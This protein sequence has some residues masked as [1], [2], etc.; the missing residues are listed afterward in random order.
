[1]SNL[2][3]AS[4]TH[5]RVHSHGSLLRSTA[6]V[7]DL[8]QRAAA[9]G[10]K[11]LALTDSQSLYSAVQFEQV[12]RTAGLQSIVGM[13]VRLAVDGNGRSP[14]QLILLATGPAGYQSLCRL[15]A[16]LQAH[17]DRE[18]RLQTGLSWDD[19]RANHDGLICIEAGLS[20]WLAHYWQTGQRQEATHFAGR[21]AAIFTDRCYLGLELHHREDKALARDLIQLGGRFG[22]QP[23]VAQPITHLE[24]EDADLLPLLAAIERNG[25]IEDIQDEIPPGHWLS[26]AEIEERFADFPE[27]IANV[28]TIIKQCQPALPN[29]RTIWPALDLPAGQTVEETLA[30]QTRTALAKRKPYSVSDNGLQ[31]TDYESRL[32]KELAAITSQSFA[33]LFL[34]VADI[35]RFA[36]QEDVPVST[37]G[38][39]ANSLVAYLLGITTVDPVEQGLLF[40]RFLNPARANLPDIDL[41]FCSRRRDEV[42]AYVRRRYGEDRVAMVGTMNTLQPKSAIRETAKAY[43]LPEKR[44]KQ[45][46]ALAPR[47]WH[48]DPRR[49]ELADAE[50]IIAGLEDETDQTIMRQAFR[51]VGQPDH[52]SLHPGGIIITPGPLTNFVPVQWA[53]KGFLTTQYD[54]RDVE[55]IGLPKIDLLGIRALTVLADTAVAIRTHHNPNFRLADIPLDDPD[56]GDLLARGETIGVFQCESSGA[57]RTLRQLRARTVRDLAVAN[58]FFKPGP[59]TGG[60]A[61]SFVRRYRGEEKV[62]YLHPSLEPI[63]APTQGVLLFQEQVLRIA[64]EIAGLSWAQAD[65]LRRGMSKFRAKEMAAMRLA[66]VM[67]CQASTGSAT[68]TPP[69]EPVE[70]APFTPQQA[71]TLWEQVLA[72]AGY[73]FNQGHATAYA[74]V[75]YRSAYLKTHYPAEFLRARLMDHGGFHHPAVYIAEARRLGFAVR[76]PHVNFSERKVTLAWEQGQKQGSKGAGEQRR[77]VLW[78]GLG[79]IRQLRRQ[80]V[81]EI[82]AARPF[83]NLRDLLTRV[84]L[85]TKEIN[86]LIQC[87]ALD[88]LGESRAALLA[89]AES[90]GRAE[91]ARQLAFDFGEVTAVPPEAAAQRFEWEKYILGMPISVTPL[92]L[93]PQSTGLPIRDLPQTRGKRV[94]VA[95]YRLPGWTGGKGWFL[96][97]GDSF[98]IAQSKEKPR[99]WEE[100][101]VMNGRY[102][103]DEW[104]GGWFQIE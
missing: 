49:R 4:F 57:Q 76:P 1:M 7:D 44:I 94:T 65:H 14:H 10:M 55:M 95:G 13:T 38:S 86:H 101:V 92:E 96:C 24:P 91:S 53:A 37:R 71:E 104:G 60:M 40:E 47:R 99:P 83:T 78:L 52:L 58:A 63:L 79:Q 48:P 50:E 36:R 18:N 39:V 29:G 90:I 64:V 102:R 75:S 15:S 67:G 97:D 69:T 68:E 6:S 25:R 17:P 43:G 28:T 31:I 46:T 32:E 3:P 100:V 2:D 81:K 77:P 66:F 89:E 80:S 93:A 59:A 20:G 30:A 98:I 42:L 73:G 74:D 19:L 22:I 11:A 85:Q 62:S 41:D 87:G 34:L 27:A 61:Q 5:L 88:E 56:T 82:V 33:P 21:L 54:Y 8:V 84:P 26:P 9:A 45:L 103:Q 35:V 70:V 51:L 23:V 12:C 72:F 16:C